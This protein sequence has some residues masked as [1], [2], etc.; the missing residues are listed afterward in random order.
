MT[1]KPSRLFLVFLCCLFLSACSADGIKN[2][3]LNPDNTN[4]VVT[5]EGL[6]AEEEEK[7]SLPVNA[8]AENNNTN[9]KSET[10]EEKTAPVNAAGNETKPLPDKMQTGEGSMPADEKPPKEE[11]VQ[12]TVTVSFTGLDKISFE[13]SIEYKDGM[14]VLE[15]TLLAA[16]GAEFTIDYTGSKSSAYIRGIGGLYEKEH[17]P[18][19]GWCYYVGGERINKGA[20]QYALK[21]GDTVR[22][23][24]QTEF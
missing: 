20:G 17:G 6:P 10:N 4:V 13:K 5:N 7:T 19:S 16:E 24:Y 18:M 1:I 23:V 21:A 15:A 14:T 3:A 22:W 8:S 2:E 11:T 12:Q 9:D